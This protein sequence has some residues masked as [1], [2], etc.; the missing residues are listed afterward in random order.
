MKKSLRLFQILPV[1]LLYCF[2]I[3]FYSS[4]VLAPQSKIFGTNAAPDSFFSMAA[5]N[6]FSFISKPES[7]GAHSGHL[8]VPLSKTKVTTCQW[9][10]EKIL[11]EKQLNRFLLSKRVLPKLQGH[12]IIFPFHYFY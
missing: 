2:I 3:S 6:L 12:N 7:P 9:S 11:I 8:G 5:S 10:S 1:L 4:N